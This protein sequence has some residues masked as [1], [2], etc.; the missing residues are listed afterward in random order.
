MLYIAHTDGYTHRDLLQP[1]L[2]RQSIPTV[3]YVVVVV[4]VLRRPHPSHPM[5]LM[6]TLL[7]PKT[8]TSP[9]A[10]A[11]QHQLPTELTFHTS[12]CTLARGSPRPRHRSARLRPEPPHELPATPHFSQTASHDCDHA[13]ST[14]CPSKR[15][16]ARRSQSRP[17]RD[18]PR[19]C[20]GWVGGHA[21]ISMRAEALYGGRLDTYEAT[22]GTMLRTDTSHPCGTLGA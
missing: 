22:S 7:I 8:C 4:T 17:P 18:R 16:A 21:A 12:I 10:L 1:S 9:L 19:F 20:R 14:I 5:M 3:L 15:H 2:S 6:P 11:A 13:V